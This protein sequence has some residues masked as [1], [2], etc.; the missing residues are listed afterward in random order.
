MLAL[1]YTKARRK[2]HT[3]LITAKLIMNKFFKIKETMSKY[4]K[5]KISNHLQIKPL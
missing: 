1:A 3:P 2:T 5:W 4:I